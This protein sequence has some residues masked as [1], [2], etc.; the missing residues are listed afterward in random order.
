MKVE[1]EMYP[2]CSVFENAE[3]E[4]EILKDEPM[5]GNIFWIVKIDGKEYDGVK[6]YKQVLKIIEKIIELEK[7]L[8]C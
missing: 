6:N 1:L 5:N 8:E 3:K 4:F 2:D 7:L